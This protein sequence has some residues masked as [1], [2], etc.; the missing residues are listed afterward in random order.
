VGMDL[1]LYFSPR[2]CPLFPWWDINLGWCGLEFNAT[3][4]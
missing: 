3:Q 1:T 4:L 2:Y